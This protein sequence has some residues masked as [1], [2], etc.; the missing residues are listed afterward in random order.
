[1]KNDYFDE[2]NGKNEE[3]EENGSESEENNDE[4]NDDNEEK[5][6]KKESEDSQEPEQNELTKGEENQSENNDE[7]NGEEGENKEEEDGDGEE[8]ELV[9]EEDEYYYIEYPNEPTAVSFY[10]YYETSQF[11]SLVIEKLG[12]VKRYGVGYYPNIY[13]LTVKRIDPD[14]LVSHNEFIFLIDL[15]EFPDDYSF[16]VGYDE[17]L[18]YYTAD[19]PTHLVHVEDPPDENMWCFAAFVS[20]KHGIILKTSLKFLFY[21]AMEDIDTNYLE[22]HTYQ[23]LKDIADYLK[24]WDESWDYG[25]KANRNSDFIRRITLGMTLKTENILKFL[26]Q[27]PNFLMDH[28]CEFFLVRIYDPENYA[29]L[30]GGESALGDLKTLFDPDLMSQYIPLFL[31][32]AQ[33]Q[34]KLFEMMLKTSNGGGDSLNSPNLSNEFFTKLIEFMKMKIGISSINP[35]IDFSGMDDET[36]ENL[37]ITFHPIHMWRPSQ[38]IYLRFNSPSNKII[39]NSNLISENVAILKT[40]FDNAKTPPSNISGRPVT[41]ED[42]DKMGFRPGYHLYNTPQPKRDYKFDEGRIFGT[43]NNKRPLFTES[44][45]NEI[46]QFCEFY[47]SYF[48]IELKII[49]P[50]LNS[51]TIFSYY[52]ILDKIKDEK[53]GENV[54]QEASENSENPEENSKGEQGKQ[55]ENLNGEQGENPEEEEIDKKKFGN[56]HYVIAVN[57][58]LFTQ[59]TQELPSRYLK[60]FIYNNDFS[61]IE[62]Y[63]IYPM[64]MISQIDI[65]SVSKIGEKILPYFTYVNELIDVII[66]LQNKGWNFDFYFQDALNKIEHQQPNVLKT[67]Y[68]NEDD[69][70]FSVDFSEEEVKTLNQLESLAPYLKEIKLWNI[71]KDNPDFYNKIAKA[72]GSEEEEEDKISEDEEEKD[73]V[74]KWLDKEYPIKIHKAHDDDYYL[75]RFLN[76]HYSDYYDE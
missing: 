29:K 54:K 19:R 28:I 9:E 10:S 39:E 58:E 46:Q 37:K 26:S 17:I 40:H 16:L 56:L 57:K 55:G 15:D 52:D 51:V 33:T 42:I 1:M 38:S 60:S 67:W 62:L 53:Q 71:Q 61:N 65:E 8:E 43:A 69:N 66:E 68:F 30:L 64:Q 73:E 35:D 21:L 75:S 22:L 3:E 45:Y 5:E 59:F 23:S 70:D 27:F 49:P 47:K 14:T 13:R 11:G 20:V 4:G 34:A 76:G 72:F 36:F 41:W 48:Q 25:T 31:K 18:Q 32:Q 7:E 50:E 63:Y 6:D 12:A 74:Q 44:R 2:E 24:L